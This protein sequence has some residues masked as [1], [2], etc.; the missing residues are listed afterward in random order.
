MRFVEFPGYGVNAPREYINAD[1]V[2]SFHEISYNGQYGTE[3]ALDDGRA[4]RVEAWSSDVKKAL[5]AVE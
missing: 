4:I 5:E 2:Q 1:M 3:I